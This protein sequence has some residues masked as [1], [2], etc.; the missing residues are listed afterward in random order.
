M[1]ARV[2]ST[3]P[4][5]PVTARVAQA[6]RAEV[7]YGIA[8]QGE[9]TMNDAMFRSLTLV[10]ASGF[11]IISAI[12]ACLLAGT[13]V[14]LSL[15]ARYSALAED[16]AKNAGPR[17]TFAFTVLNRIV[18]GAE[19]AARRQPGAINTQAII[20]DAF[21]VELKGWLIGERFVRASAGLT[22]ILGLVGTFYGLTLSIGKLVALVSGDVSEAT[23]ITEAITQGLTR[24]LTGMSVAFSTSLFG[25]LAA[26]VMTL[27]GVFMSVA[28]RRT[29]VMAQIEAFVDNVLLAAMRGEAQQPSAGIAGP[30]GGAVLP[31]AQALERLVDGFGRSVAQLQGTVVQFETALAAFSTT[32]RDFRE[33]NLHL[34]DNVQRMSL[35]FGDLSET[36]KDHVRTLKARD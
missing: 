27:L 7:S 9:P 33:F 19:A 3:K 28:D 29:V 30:A 5:A 34:K 23:E 36:L 20:D 12:V 35:S 15:R 31:S 16:L 6:G 1:A 11:I 4:S 25:I 2:A 32:T 24:A 10:D 22:I 21:Q 26:I 14:T 18:A 8:K 17:P 13:L